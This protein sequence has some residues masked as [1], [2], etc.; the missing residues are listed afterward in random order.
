MKKIIVVL[1]LLFDLA[2]GFSQIKYSLTGYIK[3]SLSSETLIGATIS[4]NGKER[5]VNS[6]QYGFYSITLPAGKYRIST[7]YVGYQSKETEIELS[8]NTAFNFLLAPKVS[9][10]EEVFVYSKR[11][12]GNVKNAQMGKIDLSM[13]QVKALPVLFGEVDILKTIQLLPGVSNAGE[14]NTGLYVRGGGPDQ[15]LIM[16]DDAIVYN[17]GHLFGF[18]SIFNSDAIK[19][20]S[21]RNAR[22][23]W[24]QT[25]IGIGC[26]D[27]RRKHE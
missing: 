1:L 26:D 8:R 27:E 10:N 9:T 25:F 16:L 17:T 7:S 21:L 20:T 15:N 22:A 24:R 19:N 6:N 4:V 23:V 11:R 12:D 3:D 2:R 14:G 5:G 18:F 13:S